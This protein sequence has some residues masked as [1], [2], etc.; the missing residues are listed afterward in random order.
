MSQEDKKGTLGQTSDPVKKAHSQEEIV[1]S[2]TPLTIPYLEIYRT[3]ELEYVP[4]QSPYTSSSSDSGDGSDTGDGSSESDSVQQAKQ[5]LTDELTKIVN[6]FY[7]ASK[8]PSKW[9]EKLRDANLDWSSVAKVVNKM[10]G[11]KNK[12]NK[13]IERVL[14][15]KEQAA[16]ITRRQ[17]GMA[18]GVGKFV[19]GLANTQKGKII[20]NAAKNSKV[21]SGNS[22]TGYVDDYTT[23]KL[24]KTI[25][26]IS[27]LEK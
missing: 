14:Q 25:E 22:K 27:K 12:Q 24:A 7:P 1:P 16:K 23:Q 4:Y 3:N 20:L 11:D 10:G 9:V 13:V 26:T 17:L 6:E 5:T 19:S 21:W 18:K 15:A 2:T 8:N